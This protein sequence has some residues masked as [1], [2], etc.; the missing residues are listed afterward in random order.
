[1]LHSSSGR[2]IAWLLG[3]IVLG[4]TGALPL[5]AEEL[6]V[7]TTL[8]DN[9]HG[10]VIWVVS[11]S[12]DGKTLASADVTGTIRVWDVDGS[13]IT[14]TLRESVR[15]LQA[16]AFSPDGKML[17][18]GGSDKV[19]LWDVASGKTAATLEVGSA[20]ALTFS[21]D[22]KLLAFGGAD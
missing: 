7:R 4:L 14:A 21:V 10:P 6:K 1:M 18:L 22:T 16:V 13:K 20:S 17:A 12:P 19:I 2:R 3:A 15:K 11:F 8:V 5:S 9:L